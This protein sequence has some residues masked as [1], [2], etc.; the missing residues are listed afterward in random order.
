MS[1]AA[2]LS[3]HV[4]TLI[5]LRNELRDMR[6][7]MVYT[8]AENAR[9]I[10]NIAR[11]VYHIVRAARSNGARAAESFLGARH[12]QE[13]DVG[14]RELMS[15]LTGTKKKLAGIRRGLSAVKQEEA[16][17][18]TGLLAALEGFRAA[19]GAQQDAA[20]VGAAARA[21]AQGARE[22]A[23]QAA[24]EDLRQLLAR[25]RAQWEEGAARAKEATG[26]LEAEAQARVA[27]GE[28]RLAALAYD[29]QGA[30]DDALGLGGR[31]GALEG[32]LASAQG[33]WAR[34]SAGLRKALHALE[35]AWR[36]GNVTAAA[37]Q[38]LHA[39][40]VAERQ[41][42]LAKRLIERAHAAT[43]AAAAAA[44]PPAPPFLPFCSQQQTAAA[45][46]G[47]ARE[48]SPEL[49]EG[50]KKRVCF[51]ARAHISVQ[52]AAA[53]LSVP[54]PLHSCI[55]RGGGGRGD[56]EEGGATPSTSSQ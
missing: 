18:R 22:L 5:D 40:L 9:E 44:A 21:Q 55:A 32:Q 20:R 7:I 51:Q 31:V 10:D 8:R 35:M 42:V 14:R 26:A 36:R 16:Q 24:M 3:R 41:G 19:L 54:A 4:E 30:L 12:A 53:L 39:A 45:A 47:R 52:R 11:E 43:A 50:A 49:R 15:V 37:L 33:G 6:S 17:Q 46:R 25:E 38:G 48:R 2:V 23:A 29:L 28:A 13:R 56:G 34:A 27:A 1:S